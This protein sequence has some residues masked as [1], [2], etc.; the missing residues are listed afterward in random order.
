MIGLCFSL[1]LVQIDSY[2]VISVFMGTPNW[3]W[4]FV[5]ALDVPILGCFWTSGV[6]HDLKWYLSPRQLM[7]LREHII[8]V[9]SSKN[10]CVEDL[11]FQ[12]EEQ[13]YKLNSYMPGKG[14]SVHSAL[15]ELRV[16]PDLT[17]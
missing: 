4:V 12:R 8:I 13:F 15:S 11:T 6:S 1:V 7:A 14:G 2:L 9:R 10:S 5:D 16:L 3:P 17:F